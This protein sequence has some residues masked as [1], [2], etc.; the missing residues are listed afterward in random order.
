M[1]FSKKTHNHHAMLG[2]YF[3][4]YNWCRK[5]ATLKTTLK[6]ISFKCGVPRVSNYRV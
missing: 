5:H 6:R 2:L 3:A 4:W 1:P